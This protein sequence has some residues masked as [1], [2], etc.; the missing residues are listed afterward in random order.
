[1]VTSGAINI[2]SRFS[3]VVASSSRWMTVC[4]WAGRAGFVAVIGAD[5]FVIW[6]YRSGLITARQF[7]TVQSGLAG[8]VVGGFAGGWAG[9]EAGASTGGAIGAR[10][11]LGGAAVGAAIGGFVGGVMGA[12]GGGYLGSTCAVGGANY[13]YRLKDE[14]HDRRYQDFLYSHYGVN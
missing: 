2:A 13:Y 10:F 3:Q 7:W 5:A 12:F 8:G 4:K 11:G 14:E 9:V 6:Q 1:M